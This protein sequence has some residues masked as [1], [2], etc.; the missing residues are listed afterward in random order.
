ML[1]ERIAAARRAAVNTVAAVDQIH[2]AL[3]GRGPHGLGLALPGVVAA[4]A[5]YAW[6]GIKPS[7]GLDVLDLR[8]EIGTAVELLG[9]HFMRP[10]GETLLGPSDRDAIAQ[11]AAAAEARA[12][13]DEGEPIR[14][15]ALAALAGVAERT[16]RA[17]T[18]PSRP[19]A[20]P[21]VKDGHWT[22]IEARHA[23]EW[24]SRRSDFAPT[25][26]SHSPQVTSMDT[27]DALANACRAG[28][29]RRG[30]DIEQ[31]ASALEW[32]LEQ[33][34]GYRAIEASLANAASLSLSPSAWRAF[35]AHVGIADSAAFAARAYRVVALA[36]ADEN[37]RAEL[38]D[39]R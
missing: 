16:I 25:R 3:S 27:L 10:G 11:V 18:N 19:N 38:G 8:H 5:D 21:I 7:E 15:D 28:R 29:A 23:L 12:D 32:S 9:G 22:W 2:A 30:V 4:L 35:A 39:S 20:I 13:L 17:A 14:I 6:R 33:V 24:L 34:A 36:C 1:N 37:I 31:L 26:A